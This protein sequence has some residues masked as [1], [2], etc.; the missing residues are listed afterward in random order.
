MIDLVV[1][2]LLIPHLKRLDAETVVE[3]KSYKKVLYKN[4]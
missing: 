1:D 4:N 3:E 2:F